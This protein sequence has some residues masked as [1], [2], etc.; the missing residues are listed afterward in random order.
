MA[1]IQLTQGKKAIVD[2]EDLAELSQ[3]NWQ[4]HKKGYAYTTIYLGKIGDKYRGTTIKMHRLLTSCPVDKQV[5][6]K[7]G[8]GLDNRKSNL[9]ICTATQNSYN[10]K[11]HKNNKSGYKGVGTQ[12]NDYYVEIGFKGKRIYLGRY[13]DPVEAAKVYDK[14][15]KKYHGEFARLNFKEI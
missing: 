11:V 8:N 3:Y 2:A 5:D 14:A 13:K 7:N 12:K 9:R 10:R 15:A 6:H 4:F 1:Y